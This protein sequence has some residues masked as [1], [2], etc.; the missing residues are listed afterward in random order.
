MD[1]WDGTIHQWRKDEQAGGGARVETE[2][3][4]EVEL[5]V[6]RNG[7]FLLGAS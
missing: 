6:Q 5:Q 3:K 7:S 1:A 4:V 2:T